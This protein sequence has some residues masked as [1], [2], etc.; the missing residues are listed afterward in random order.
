MS[1]T[2]P[3]AKR[4]RPTVEIM[5]GFPNPFRLVGTEFFSGMLGVSSSSFA[6]YLA[7]GA[8]PA[9]DVK[10]GRLSRW[11]ETTVA[12]VLATG[13]PVLERAAPNSN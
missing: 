12:S 1:T 9:A 11:K 13:V 6:R 3:R 8:L 5:D 7:A 4:T 10:V 2:T